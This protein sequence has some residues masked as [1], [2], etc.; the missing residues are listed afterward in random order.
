MKDNINPRSYKIALLLIRLIPM[1][2]ALCY[3]ANSLLAFFNH[4]LEII[5]YFVLI[6]FVILLY[7]LSYVFRFCSYH[8]MFIHYIVIV[9]I[10][11]IIDYYIG[12][13][14]DEAQLFCAYL[15]MTVVMM[16][17]TLYLY[18][19]QTKHNKDIISGGD[20]QN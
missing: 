3:G 9:D 1:I 18:V 13:P 2:V 5:G 10:T 19:K 15:I 6:L 14:M 17:I 20:R 4:D 8:R 16:F 12:I 11:N 7:I